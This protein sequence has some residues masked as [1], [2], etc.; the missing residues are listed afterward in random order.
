[1][2][3]T[4]YQKENYT[5][6][7]PYLLLYKMP[8]SSSS[9]ATG[10]SV[11]TDAALGTLTT[12]ENSHPLTSFFG[13]TAGHHEA[14][15]ADDK[16]SHE[17][18][19]L[20]RAYVGKN[21]YL[22]ETLD[23]M[24]RKEDEF[25]TRS[26]LP[27]EYTDELHIAWEIFSFNRTLADLE[28]H[29]GLPRF[30]TQES[31]SHTDNLLRRGLAFIIEHGFYKTERGKRHFALNLQQ[32]TDAVHT[33][34]YFGVIHA[35]LGGKSY[36]RE[37]RRKFGRQVNRRNDLFRE[38]RK[39]WAIVQKSRDGLY[40]LD[41]ELKHELKREGVVP[42]L[43]VF[44][45]KMG[46]Y[47][48]MVSGDALSYKERGPEAVT[49]R[50]S[51]DK[52]ASFRGLPVFEAQSFD[53]EFTSEPVDL[54]VRERQCGEFFYVEKTGEISI[55][56]ADSDKFE[57][58]LGSDITNDPKKQFGTGASGGENGTKAL[59]SAGGT[60]TGYILFRPFQ[61]Y[62][63]AS[64][65]LAK[66]GSELGNTY[67]G[68][69]DFMLSDDILRKVHVGHYTFYS[70]SVVKRPKN[71]IIVEDIFSQGYVGGEGTRLFTEDEFKKAVDENTLGK[72][73][74]S[75]I[76]VPT[77][78]P[79]KGDVLDMTGRFQQSVYDIFNE[80]DAQ[81]EHYAG[82]GSAYTAMNLGMLEPYRN[83]IND[84]YIMRVQRYNTVCF[85]GMQYTRLGADGKPAA[86]GAKD[87]EMKLTQ[88]NT[89]HWGP[90]I[91]AGVRKV[92][93]GEM[94]FMKQCDHTAITSV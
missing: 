82:S 38:E 40:L 36:Y 43:W 9:A 94:A 78:E 8:T 16:L 4:N 65:I 3:L 10:L 80:E 17:T 71:Y 29:Q 35:L 28:P 45:D 20:P 34:C 47:V 72:T 60:V 70:K 79:P 74:P 12:G 31:E 5:I 86:A 11:L 1:M 75:I 22:E 87:S 2:A 23:F 88:L 55:Y 56:D 27:W 58:I 92:R 63:M 89:G 81:D 18:Y 14:L 52:I 25:Y 69:H 91:Y 68:H 57:R 26:L 67:H 66:G 90:N 39:R 53:V 41:A 21:K 19:N 15:R 85:R 6:Y 32:I 13:P 7:I 54:M 77:T 49:N 59:G 50:E 84:E 24:I 83:N 33:T 44:P 73:G 62:R 64:A 51:G 93:E 46:I 61:T 42:S 30:V 76:A 37:W 48:H